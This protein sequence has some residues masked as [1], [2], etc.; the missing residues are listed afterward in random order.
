MYRYIQIVIVTL[1]YI[2]QG[3]LCISPD[4]PDA[5]SLV[6]A[7]D[8]HDDTLGSVLGCYDGNVYE[9]MLKSTQNEPLNQ[10]DAS[11]SQI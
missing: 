1:Y 6:D 10:S 4:R 5:V 8:I 9:R 7:F 11:I 2:F 3:S